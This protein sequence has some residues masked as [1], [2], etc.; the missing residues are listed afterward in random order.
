MTMAM[1]MMTIMIIVTVM[2][3]MMTMTMITYNDEGR[4]RILIAGI[5]HTHVKT[6][7]THNYRDMFLSFVF[8]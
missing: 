5:E 8:L 2:T 7:L 4:D 6:C 3:M 1:T